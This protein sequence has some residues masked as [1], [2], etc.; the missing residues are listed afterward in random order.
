MAIRSRSR[1]KKWRLRNTAETWCNSTIDNA[2]LTIPGYFWRSEKIEWTLRSAQGI[3]G[4]LIE[5]AKEGWRLEEE[6]E[7]NDFNQ[8]SKFKVKCGAVE[9]TFLLIYRSP[10][11][12]PEATE[13]LIEIVEKAEKN[14]F[15]IGDFNYPSIDWERGTVAGR[16]ARD[17]LMATEEK[18]MAQLVDFPTHTRGNTL[19]LVITNS[20]ELVIGLEEEGRLGRSDHVLLEMIIGVDN[21]PTKEDRKKFV[22]WKKA[23]WK[24]IRRDID[25]VDWRT[26]LEGSTANE[27]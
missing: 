20:P 25:Q 21:R 3:R 17:F 2:L 1:P 14:T 13:K 19:D 12:A 10:N 26:E 7:V 8:H 24:Q 5:Y 6:E 18:L 27:A 15:L 4:G 11:A 23:D 9:M 16:K 22:D